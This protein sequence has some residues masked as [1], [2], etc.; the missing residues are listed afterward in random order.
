MYALHERTYAVRY[1]L[2]TFARALRSRFPVV[3][4]SGRTERNGHHCSIIVAGRQPA[5]TYLTEFIFASPSE[6][7][8]LGNVPLWALP[9]LLTSLT[10]SVDLVIARVDT[11]SA[12]LLFDSNHLHAPE[13]VELW[14]T[15][16]ADL[17]SL[18]TGYHNK[19]L[20]KDLRRVARNGIT[21]ELSQSEAD[22][23]VYY[24]DFYVPYA[25]LRFGTYS[26]LTSLAVLRRRLKYGGLRWAVR[27]GQRLA[28]STFVHGN[29]VY[30]SQT[31]G[32]A[33]GDASV[34]Q[35]GAFVALYWAAI[36]HAHALGCKEV[37][38]GGSQA[39][40]TDGTLRFKRKF[41]A[42]LVDRGYSVRRLL[43]WSKLNPTVLTLLR[44]A[45]LIFREGRHLSALS[46]LELNRPAEP[47]EVAQAYR[48]LHMPGLDGIH[49][50]SAAG[51]AHDVTAPPR[52]CLVDLY[53]LR[54]GNLPELLSAGK[55]DGRRPQSG[56]ASVESRAGL[57]T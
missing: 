19:G 17:S 44:T 2:R 34:L 3:R 7:T 5:A 39:I 25:R 8:V 57:F 32:A 10:P 31:I 6:S 12:Q 33:E 18:T 27:D 23:E 42:R 51:F 29:I 53:A 49:L 43:R 55:V 50:L 36:E 41:G 11:L 13:W 47:D 46:M 30:R 14:L 56:A 22:L 9:R 48:F 26:Q 28:G 24:H 37:D 4:L 54:N 40:L 15:V 21:C 45:P 20:K 35:S 16:P 1:R 52:T 38:F